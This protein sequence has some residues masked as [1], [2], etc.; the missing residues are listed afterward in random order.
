MLNARTQAFVAPVMATIEAH[1]KTITTA[2]LQ[3]AMRYS[4]EAGGKRLRPLLL[5]AVVDS[6]QGDVAAALPAA[7]ALECLHTYSLI[8]DD[9]PAMDNDD[10]RRG[11]P[12]N[13]K[14]FGEALAILAGDALQASAFTLLGQTATTPAQLAECLRLFAQAVGAQGMVGGQVLDIEG[15]QQHLDLPALRHLHALKTGALIEAAVNLGAVLA[16]VPAAD[17]KAL[18][19]FASAFGIAFQIQDD[20]N[21]VTK[22]SAELGKTANKDVAEHKNTYPELL[23]L[24]GAQTALAEQVATARTALMSLSRPVPQLVAFLTYFG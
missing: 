23:G 3:E 15:E 4:L 20:I 14:R 18:A 12:T 10:L 21:D 8:H 19:Q 11:K 1:L 22:T 7:A 16:A 13:H 9:L 6:Y 24:A 2:P 5:L 17:Q